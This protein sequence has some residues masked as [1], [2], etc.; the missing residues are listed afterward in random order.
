MTRVKRCPGLGA[1]LGQ[2]R[3]GP[4]CEQAPEA[5]A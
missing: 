2:R 3:L 1:A 5:A 4:R